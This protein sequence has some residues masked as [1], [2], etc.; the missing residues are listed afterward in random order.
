MTEQAITAA[1]VQQL[2]DGLLS[3]VQVAGVAVLLSTDGLVVASSSGLDR[4]N[5][6]HLSALVAGVQGLARGAC[7]RFAGGA[8]MQ[9]V[10]EMD[11]ALV[12][13]VPAGDHACLAAVIPADSDAGT[14]AYELTELAERLAERPP[15][16]PRLSG[17]SAR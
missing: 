7:N 6:D 13:M 9:S 15:V 11:T 4:E 16:V 1:Q 14:V 2:L 8:L 12:F 5:A 10:I 17:S 3:R